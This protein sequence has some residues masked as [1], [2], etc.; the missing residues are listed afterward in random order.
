M[1]KQ[2][3]GIL[4]FR[5]TNIKAGFHSPSPQPSPSFEFLLVHPGGPFWAGKDEHAWSIPKGEFADHENAEFAAR[6]EFFEETGLKYDGNLT[7][8]RPVTTANGKIIQAF[9]GEGDFDPATLKS[10]NFEL[11]WPPRSG[12]MQSFPE[13]DKAG[14]FDAATAKTKIHKGQV[15]I[16]ELV[17]MMGNQ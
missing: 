11:E 5:R 7:A 17:E 6:R 8:L 10:N 4:L 12:K 15:R 2:S 14:W 3:A 1:T 9:L 13:V 16:I